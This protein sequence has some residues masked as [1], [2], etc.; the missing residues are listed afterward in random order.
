MLNPVFLDM[1]E[2]YGIFF[3]NHLCDVTNRILKWVWS[4]NVFPPAAAP[5]LFS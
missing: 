3:L 2:R 5:L 4:E 1:H